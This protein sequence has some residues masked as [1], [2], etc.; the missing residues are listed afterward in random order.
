[1]TAWS[2]DGSVG[3]RRCIIMGR[4]QGVGGGLVFGRRGGADAAKAGTGT[5]G[6]GGAVGLMDFIPVGP[7]GGGQKSR[8]RF[9]GRRIT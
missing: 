7:G 4:G 9:V 3:G 6:G 8:E 1:M 2:R 5:G